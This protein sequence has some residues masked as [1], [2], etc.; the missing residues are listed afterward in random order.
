MEYY[1]MQR[2][3]DN[4]CGVLQMDENWEGIPPH[5]TSY[6]AVDDTDAACEQAAAAGGEVRVPAFHTPFGRIAV[7]SDPFGATFS[8]VQM[9]AA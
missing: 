8:V 3:D 2:G 4:I 1:T 5:W 6:F 7:L 9:A